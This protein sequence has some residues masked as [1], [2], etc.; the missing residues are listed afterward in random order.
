MDQN[1]PIEVMICAIEEVQL[2]LL[3]HPKSDQE[4]PDLAL[5]KFS[6]IEL[7]KTGVYSKLIER[8]NKKDFTDRQD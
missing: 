8:W 5:I 1:E 4:L 7:M 6:L 3:S 2:F